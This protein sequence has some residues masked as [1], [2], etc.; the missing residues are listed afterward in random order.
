M[1]GCLNIGSGNLEVIRCFFF[2]LGRLFWLSMLLADRYQDAAVEAM[3]LAADVPGNIL[4][5]HGRG[6]LVVYLASFGS[7]V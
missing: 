5:C 3:V 1:H 7:F 6:S 4:V 2:S